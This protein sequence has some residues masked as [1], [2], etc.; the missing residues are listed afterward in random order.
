MWERSLELLSLRACFPGVGVA[1]LVENLLCRKL[2]GQSPNTTSNQ[3]RW[4]MLSQ[5]FE[6]RGKMIRIHFQPGR[7][8]PTSIPSTGEA[9]DKES[10]SLSNIRDLLPLFPSTQV[11]EKHCFMSMVSF[12]G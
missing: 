7:V 6:G 11:T 10:F 2:L 8:A 9:E 5:H 4:H 3:A 1:R 12:A